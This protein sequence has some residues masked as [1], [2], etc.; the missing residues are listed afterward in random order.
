MAITVTKEQLASSV[1]VVINGQT[2][3]QAVSDDGTTTLAEL[4]NAAFNEGALGSSVVTTNSDGS[5]T[6]GETVYVMSQDSQVKSIT[7]DGNVTVECGDR[8]LLDR[9]HH[10]G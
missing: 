1:I 5:L 7:K 10:N 8:V 3:L 6:L 2:R 9:K 4:L